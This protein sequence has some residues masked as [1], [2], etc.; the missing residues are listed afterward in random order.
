MILK[1]QNGSTTNTYNVQIT[2][3]LAKFVKPFIDNE[4]G[5][6][7][8]ELRLLEKVVAIIKDRCTLLTDFWAQGHFFFTTPEI[9][10]SLPIK[11]KMNDQKQDFFMNW[12]AVLETMEDGSRNHRNKLQ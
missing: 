2:L 1:K 7:I 8:A 5:T 6:G 12:L 10:E 9:I 4:L 11:E 3:S